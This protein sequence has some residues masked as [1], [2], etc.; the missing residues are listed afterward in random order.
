ML[1]KEA[2]LFST[3]LSPLRDRSSYL[4]CSC[5]CGSVFLTGVWGHLPVAVLGVML[6]IFLCA[7]Q[8]SE[9]PLQ[10]NCSSVL[11]FLIELLIFL[12]CCL[13]ESFLYSREV[14]CQTHGGLPIVP[15]GL[16]FVFSSS[17]QDLWQR[18]H[19]WWSSMRRLRLSIL[20]SWTTCLV[21]SPGTVP[22]PHAKS[23]ILWLFRSYMVNI[24]HN[25][26]G[27]EFYIWY[28]I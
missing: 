3:A 20:L 17:W 16:Q 7:H 21:S 22:V 14:V 27:V 8:Q 19:S 9:Y 10:W 6:S 26:F 1:S 5:Y 15:P 23:L 4:L 2:T 24:L 11:C 28:D 12:P 13:Q 18:K 25:P